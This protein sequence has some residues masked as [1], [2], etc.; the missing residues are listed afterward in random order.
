MSVHRAELVELGR[1]LLQR[2]YRFVTVTP[3]THA[4]VNE[5]A[6]DVASG[7]LRHIFGWNRPFETRQVPPELFELMRAAGACQSLT[8][9][10]WRAN[11]R[12]SSLGEQIFLHSGFPTQQADSVFFGP[13]SYRFVRAVLPYLPLSGRLVDV[14]CGSGVGGIVA[15]A[16]RRNLR[17]TLA[18]VNQAALDMARVNAALAGVDAELVQSD[19]L[20]RVD[21]H[22][23]VV[24]SNP[25]Y[26]C[27]EAQRTYRDG[28]EHH[29]ASLSAR[30]VSEVLR[31]FRGRT[32]GKLLLYSGAAVIQGRDCLLELLRPTLERHA[33]SYSYEEVDPDVFGEELA[34]PGYAEVERI[35]AV[36][37]QVSV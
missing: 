27:D 34:S 17:I 23:D 29:G 8:G 5:R 19:V 36:L 11:V 25:P 12:F 32:G 3:R 7:D 16:H 33:S 6:G 9:G 21:G 2:G 30:I 14:G 28:G 10:R 37:L 4:L 26:L 13:D 20:A 1:W 35:A 24:I 15:S 18:D 22:I 31:S